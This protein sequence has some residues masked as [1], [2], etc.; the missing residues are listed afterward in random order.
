MESILPATSLLLAATCLI[1]FI[2]FGIHLPSIL[3]LLHKDASQLVGQILREALTKKSHSGFGD[4]VCFGR[5]YPP[6]AVTSEWFPPLPGS[7]PCAPRVLTWR[8]WVPIFERTLR[9]WR[10][11]SRPVERPEVLACDLV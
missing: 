4:L 1:L 9:S 7:S 3:L 11:S 10:I 2:L 6:G 5:F 8:D